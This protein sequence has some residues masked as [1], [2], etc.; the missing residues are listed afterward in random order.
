MNKSIFLSI[1]AC[2]IISMSFYA[3]KGQS[4]QVKQHEDYSIVQTTYLDNT[5]KEYHISINDNLSYSG[6][7]HASVGK[8]YSVEYD[9]T[10]FEMQSDI[11]YN[12]PESVKA[13]MC[14]GD[15]AVKTVSFTPLKTGDYTIKVLHNF[16]GQTTDS[17]TYKISIN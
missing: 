9:T 13:G 17:M 8:S 1:I 3:C 4:T 14:G 5:S 12:N 11:K 6:E 16:R 10:A 2:S 7:V 15:K